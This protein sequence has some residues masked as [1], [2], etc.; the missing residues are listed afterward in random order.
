LGSGPLTV[1]RALVLEDEVVFA[2]LRLAMGVP[3]RQSL[4]CCQETQG[5]YVDCG[6]FRL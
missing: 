6:R 2:V 5:V 3:E 1:E 4:A